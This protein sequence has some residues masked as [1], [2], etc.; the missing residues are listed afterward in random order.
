MSPQLTQGWLPLG[1][2]AQHLGVDT[3][4][5]DALILFG[6]L[7]GLPGWPGDPRPVAC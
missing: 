3:P 6:L 7:L 5:L 4:P 2:E 1:L